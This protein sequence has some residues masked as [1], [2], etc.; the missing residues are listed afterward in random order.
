M[1]GSIIGAG[2]SALGNLAGGFIGQSGVNQTNQNQMQ[3]AQQQMQFSAEQAQKQMD[4]QE[5]MSNTQYQRAMAD[6]RSAG[7]NPMLAYSQG[8]AGNV[9]GAMGSYTQAQL[10]NPNAPLSEGV[11]KA[12]TSAKDAAQTVAGIKLAAQQV[13]QSKSQTELNQDNAAL[14]KAT[15]AKTALEMINT[16]KQGEKIDAETRNIN[17]GTITSAASAGLMGAQA[18]TA[19]ALTRLHTREAI[20]RE[21]W[22]PPGQLG[23]QLEHAGR[24]ILDM[25]NNSR[26][27]SGAAGAPPSVPTKL[28][29]WLSSDNPV[30]QERIRRNREKEQNR[31]Y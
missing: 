16:A 9:A 29:S 6:M 19:G 25:L 7:L 20:D 10:E 13:D 18:G 21:N 11:S 3:L 27:P 22:G 8:G 24:R 30:V 14:A 15:T 1:W 4:F 5:R 28:P 31:G 17:Q 2:I 23:P 26:N 12:V